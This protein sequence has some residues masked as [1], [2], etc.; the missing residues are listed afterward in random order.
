MLYAGIMRKF[1]Q[2]V[3]RSLRLSMGTLFFILF[4]RNLMVCVV[5]LFT[6]E[7]EGMSR[8][9]WQFAR[10]VGRYILMGRGSSSL[11]DHGVV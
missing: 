4:R 7:A 5:Y 1:F 6:K 3:V 10:N 11:I 9:C 2:Y 8:S